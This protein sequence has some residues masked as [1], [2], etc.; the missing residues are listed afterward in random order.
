MTRSFARP[1]QRRYIESGQ[2]AAD[3]RKRVE[4]RDR[5]WGEMEKRAGAGAQDGET[6]EAAMARM[7]GDGD[8]TISQLYAKYVG[9]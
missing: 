9:P 6:P 1:E 2:V 7:L 4:K 5:V 8:P 3:I